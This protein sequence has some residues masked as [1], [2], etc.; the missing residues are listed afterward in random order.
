[1]KPRHLLAVAVA[2]AVLFCAGC[3]KTEYTVY[4]RDDGSRYMYHH[5]DQGPL[6]T[7]CVF[8]EVPESEDHHRPPDQGVKE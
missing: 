3:G 1:M 6:D 5:A 4:V 8:K 2:V 7:S